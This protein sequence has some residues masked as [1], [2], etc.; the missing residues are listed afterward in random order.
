MLTLESFFT[1]R[2]TVST[3]R[4]ETYLLPM[5]TTELPFHLQNILQ[6]E[7]QRASIRFFDFFLIFIFLVVPQFISHFDQQEFP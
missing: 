2:F 6:N 3:G 7:N 1:L 4:W 5:L